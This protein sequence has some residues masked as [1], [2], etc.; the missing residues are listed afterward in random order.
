[1]KKYKFLL[2]HIAFLITMGAIA[3][4]NEK[5]GP[6]KTISVVQL[7]SPGISLTVQDAF[8]SL[9]LNEAAVKSVTGIPS[10]KK[11]DFD[12]T[13]LYRSEKKGEIEIGYS[14]AYTGVATKDKYAFAVFI[15]EKTLLRPML[16]RASPDRSYLIYYD[17]TDGITAEVVKGSS[18]YTYSSR[19][20]NLGNNIASRGG[21]GQAVMNCIT[22][23][24]SNHGWTSFWVT[25]Q[26]IF[27]PSTGVA[28]AIGCIAK[29]CLK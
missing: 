6:S 16:I 15:K 12:F 8:N 21:C 5:D 24:Y 4:V 20:V 9:V 29:N 23:A 17:L 2:V 1:M 18:T 22:D 7:K 13:N 3:Q 28:I 19:P 11:S 25:I 10:F 26:S 27:L 14:V